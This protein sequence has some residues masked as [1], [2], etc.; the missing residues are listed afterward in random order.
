MTENEAAVSWK[1]AK[2]T[3]NFRVLSLI[4]VGTL[5]AGLAVFAGGVFAGRWAVKDRGSER[6]HSKSK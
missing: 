3:R 2:Q 1:E 4:V 5:L 6:Y